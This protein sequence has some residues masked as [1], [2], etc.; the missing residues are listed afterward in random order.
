MTVGVYTEDGNEMNNTISDNVII[1]A[2]WMLCKFETKDNF[3]EGNHWQGES[4][5]KE[6]FYF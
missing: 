4:G 1:C 2:Q 5:V 3:A 6:G